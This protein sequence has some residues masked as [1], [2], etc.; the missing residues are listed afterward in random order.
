M[1]PVQLEIS[2]VEIKNSY[3]P[4]WKSPNVEHKL[5]NPPYTA[6]YNMLTRVMQTTAEEESTYD[7]V[8]DI[9]HAEI[10]AKSSLTV[11]SLLFWE[12][13]APRRYKGSIK[14]NVMLYD[15]DAQ[16]GSGVFEVKRDLEL[17]EA[18]SVAERDVSLNRLVEKMVSDSYTG[19]LRVL[20]DDFNLKINDAK[21]AVEPSPKM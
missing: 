9:E 10:V 7:L 5:V 4:P 21:T 19:A 3:T 13:P 18:F 6:A 1:T 2:S 8:F 16:V 12:P 20:R 15:A 17:P 14:V 11:R